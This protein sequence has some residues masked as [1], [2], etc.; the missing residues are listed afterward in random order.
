MFS[1]RL[2]RLEMS[3]LS[4]LETVLLPECREPLHGDASVRLVELHGV[5]GGAVA[6][7]AHGGEVIEGAVEEEEDAVVRGVGVW[8][9]LMVMPKMALFGTLILLLKVR[10]YWRVK[11]LL[12]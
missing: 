12:K 4:G 10:R 9:W 6:G 5:R 7:V 3:L 8:M 11:L 2:L 1:R